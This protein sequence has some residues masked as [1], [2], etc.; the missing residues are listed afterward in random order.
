ML[1][2]RKEENVLL[3]RD[4]LASTIVVLFFANFRTYTYKHATCTFD[5]KKIYD[6]V[7]ASLLRPGKK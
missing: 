3:K 1:F 4:V 5:R 7:F 6:M 2:S